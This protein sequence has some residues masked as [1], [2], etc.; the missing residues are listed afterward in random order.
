MIPRSW[1]YWRFSYEG[2]TFRVADYLRDWDRAE[3]DL[4]YRMAMREDRREPIP[5]YWRSWERPPLITYIR[6]LF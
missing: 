1:P 5:L 4:R 2:T 6:G 3:A